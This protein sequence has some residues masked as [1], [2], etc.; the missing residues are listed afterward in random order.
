M[1]NQIFLLIIF[2]SSCINSYSQTKNDKLK[3]EAK[4][5]NAC[6]FQGKEQAF[7]SRVPAGKNVQILFDKFFKTWQIKFV[8][9]DDQNVVLKFSYLQNMESGDERVESTGGYIY[10][11]R[12][13]NYQKGFNLWISAET[14]NDKDV[15]IAYEIEN[16]VEV[17]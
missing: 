6:Y 2:I 15:Y 11:L 12:K 10:L 5:I 17:T 3:Y 4:A 7:L 13:T 14:P 16:I 1:K 8:D 9:K